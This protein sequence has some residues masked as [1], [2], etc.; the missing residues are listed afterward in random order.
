MAVI[1][2]ARRT[3]IVP[4]GG[5]FSTLHPHELAAPVIA[6]MLRDT[7][8]NPGD[9]GQ[10]FLSNALGGG[11]NPAR[12]AALFSGLGP[13]SGLS[14]DAQCAGGLDAIAMAAAWVD[15][16]FAR[17][18][19]AGGSE[20]FSQRPLRAT[21]PGPDGAPRF[22]T[23]PPFSPFPEQDPDLTSAA[24]D[25]ARGLGLSRQEQDG[26]AV[27]SHR[28]A[29]AARDVLSCEIVPI[30]GVDHDAFTRRLTVNT[31]RRSK[32]L[33]GSVSVAAT[34][35]EADG[36]AFCL[37]VAD[38]MGA[39][40]DHAV[41]IRAHACVGADP[42]LPGI[43]PVAAITRVLA[44]CGLTPNDLST[45]EVMEAY[46]A[47]AIACIR[48][49]H[50]PDDRTNVSGG[51]LSRGHPIGASGAILVCRA[52]HELKRRP[53]PALCTIAA[54][55]GIGSAMVLETSVDRAPRSRR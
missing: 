20:S 22:Y 28:K 40:V 17:A 55:G 34:A 37:V 1:I 9:I 52:F 26:F 12:M 3:A 35:V 27:E 42:A 19:I 51:A 23:R 29:L 25:L 54:A 11:G 14:I 49:G 43:A 53:G 47:Q 4:R 8:L 36:A 2:A 18:V 50:L 31:A 13:V 45:I 5:A 21:Q 38:D 6:A 30:Q 16:G 7:G 46:A 33:A 48:L 32:T 24:D 15:A 10:L 39:L 44:A 41:S